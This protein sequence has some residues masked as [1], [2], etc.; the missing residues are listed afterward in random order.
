MLPVR[1]IGPATSVEIYALIDD[2]S[3]VS[4]L[5]AKI[6]VQIEVTGSR[7][8]LMLRGINGEEA[9]AYRS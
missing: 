4:L 2:G 5:D 3:T 1:A 6:A 7:V 8:Q 9:I